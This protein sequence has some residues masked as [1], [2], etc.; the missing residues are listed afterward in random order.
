MV[1]SPPFSYG[2]GEN[3]H[4]ASLFFARQSK[5]VWIRVGNCSTSMIETLLHGHCTHLQAFAV[6]PDGAFLT[7]E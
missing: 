2:N 5:V 7:L 4:H 6:E 1:A 3:S